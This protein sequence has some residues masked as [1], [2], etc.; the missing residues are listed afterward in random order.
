MSQQ[1]KH[2]GER[3]HSTAV[4]DPDARLDPTVSVDAQA[5]IGPGVE[6]GAGTRV[7]PQA[8]I[9]GPT[10]IGQNNRIHAKACLGDAPQ[11]LSYRDEETFLEVGD[12]NVI[13]EFVTMH[14][15]STKEEGVTR[16]GNDNLFMAYSHVAHDCRIGNNVTLANLVSLAGHVHVGDRVNIGGST[17]V[18]QFVHIGDYAMIGGGSIILLDVP[19]FVMAAGNRAHLYGLNRRGL[20]RAGFSPEAVR[21]LNRAYRLL[22]RSGLPLAEALERLRE[23]VPGTGTETLITFLKNSNRGV[24]R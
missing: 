9:L 14:R 10:R 15:A 8:V 4:V 6:I 17:A 3:I 18:H 16:V 23:E 1:G 21:S 12:N 22:F 20:K 19:P 5:Y 11:D 7:G 13:R 2:A 24:T